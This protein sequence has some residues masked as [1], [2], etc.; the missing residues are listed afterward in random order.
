VTVIASQYPVPADLLPIKLTPPAGFGAPVAVVITNYS[1]YIAVISNLGDNPATHNLVPGMTQAFPFSNTQGS[2]LVSFIADASITPYAQGYITAD[3]TED[4]AD[5]ANNNYPALATV[6]TATSPS[7]AVLGT[8]SVTDDTPTD[9]DGLPSWSQAVIISTPAS[10][11]AASVVTVQGSVSGIVYESNAG[12][13]VL[14][15]FTS[16]NCLI[17]IVP[18]LDPALIITV[19]MPAGVTSE[20]ITVTAVPEYIELPLPAPT[21]YGAGNLNGE[22][23]VTFKENYGGADMLSEGPWLLESLS[24]S[25]GPVADTPAGNTVSVFWGLAGFETI[26]DQFQVASI[27]EGGQFSPIYR[28]YGRVITPNTSNTAPLSNM[29]LGGA[30][31]W[32]IEATL[33]AIQLG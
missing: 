33:T 3:F 8:Q 15:A 25:A 11:N 7:V 20:D 4:P 5:I 17:P 19:Q 28:T 31:G 18:G 13:N 26:F 21:V 23:P 12:I 29:S 27:A 9:F 24:V 16:W 22:P 6:F 14:S 30:T 1:P 32:S 2:P 10:S